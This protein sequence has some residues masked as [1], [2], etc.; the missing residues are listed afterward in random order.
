MFDLRD[1]REIFR[2]RRTISAKTNN[3]DINKREYH[4]SLQLATEDFL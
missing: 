2:S 3:F 4:A 1:E